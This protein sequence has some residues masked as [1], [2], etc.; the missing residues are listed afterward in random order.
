MPTFLTALAQDYE[1]PAEILSYRGLMKLKT[2]YVDTLPGLVNPE[3]GR[4]HTSYNQTVTATGRLSS[5]NPNLQNIPIRTEEGRRIRQAFISPAG[6]EIISADYSQ[7]E[8]RI[9]AHLSGDETL[10]DIFNS[11]EDI[12]DRTAMEVFGVMPGMVNNEMRRRA[13]VINFG[14]LYGMSPFGLSKELGISQSMAKA[15]IDKYFAEFAGV[16]RY[17]ETLLAD[18][19]RDGYVTTLF[20]RR[21]YIPEINGNNYAMRQFAERMAVNTPVQGTAADLIK[22]AMINI[23]RK[24]LRDRY[25]SCLI[26]QVHDELVFE[27]PARE[28]KSLME[29]I[30]AEMEGVIRLNVPLLVD[31]KAG[32][33]WDE[34]H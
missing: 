12:H 5:S 14:I 15:Y 10:I 19:R 30:V 23:E 25:S 34:A 20:G 24:L 21:R 17:I 6:C 7:I 1:L 22:L 3:T 16:S 28:K 26:M 27:V 18:A 2:T 9:L 31:I 32:K 33:N 29:L 4:V 11:G 13:K 8:L